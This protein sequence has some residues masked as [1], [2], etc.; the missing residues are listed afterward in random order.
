MRRK[1]RRVQLYEEPD[2]KAQHEQQERLLTNTSSKNFDKAT[3]LQ[4]TKPR[5]ESEKKLRIEVR[6]PGNANR[7]DVEQ[8]CACSDPYCLRK[9][10]KSHHFDLFCAERG[11]EANT[12]AYEDETTWT[13]DDDE[14]QLYSRS[15]YKHS[16][17]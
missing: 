15:L 3:L 5:L 11:R 13:D 6:Q 4:A 8:I 9:H 10:K 12:P 16:G 7:N 17:I 14:P 2:R 1:G